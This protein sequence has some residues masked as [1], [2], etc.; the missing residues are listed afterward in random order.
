MHVTE[1]RLANAERAAVEGVTNGLDLHVETG[2]L[3]AGDVE[4]G[5]AVSFMALYAGGVA[6]LLA[7]VAGEFPACWWNRRNAVDRLQEDSV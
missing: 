4:S 3:R 2:M 6:T 7:N 5:I 1:G